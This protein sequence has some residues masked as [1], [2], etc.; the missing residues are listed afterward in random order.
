MSPLVLSLALILLLEV[1]GFLLLYRLTRWPGKQVALL[2]AVAGL[3][4]YLPWAVRDWQGLDRFAIHF[5]FIAM[6]PYGLGII[7][8]TG[9]ARRRLEGEGGQRRWFHWAPAA[10]VAFFLV[11]AAVDAVIITLAE[12]GLRGRW[13]RLLLPPP[14]SGREVVSLEQG[15]VSHPFQEREE[16]YNAWLAQ[17]QAQARRGWQV[18][19]GWLGRPVAGRATPF[20]LVVTDRD[21][22]PVAGAEVRGRFLRPSDASADFDFTL[23][24]IAP[25][26]YQAELRMP[27]AGL[28][29]VVITIRRGED[30]HE[31]RGRT[32]V[33][34]AGP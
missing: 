34:D 12:Q 16:E 18:R 3:V 33:H 29:S 11:L 5:V 10:I 4:V 2:V 22:R 14:K 27:A 25:G 23:P 13:A 19:R 20:K 8:S 21:G 31:L 1:G 26:T 24:E 32:R 9:E 6:I 15:A 17:R 28:W 30:L 7:T